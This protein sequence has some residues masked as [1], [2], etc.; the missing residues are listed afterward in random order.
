[1]PH[2]LPRPPDEAVVTGPNLLSMTPAA[3]SSRRPFGSIRAAIADTGSLASSPGRSISSSATGFS[4]G[5][6]HR[7][8]SLVAFGVPKDLVSL[9]FSVRIELIGGEGGYERVARLQPALAAGP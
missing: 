3:S 7:K 8:T 4:P 6:A 5:A 9:C 2:R 1:M